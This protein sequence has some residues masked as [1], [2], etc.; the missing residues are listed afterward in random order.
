MII[1][2]ASHKGLANLNV[3]NRCEVSA[4]INGTSPTKLSRVVIRNDE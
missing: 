4:G 3:N 1:I 2:R